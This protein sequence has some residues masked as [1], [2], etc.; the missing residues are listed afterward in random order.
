MPVPDSAGA[1]QSPSSRTKRH[2]YT[3]STYP[4]PPTTAVTRTSPA[5]HISD[6]GMEEC[7][8]IQVSETAPDRPAETMLMQ[9]ADGTILTSAA[10]LEPTHPAWTPQQPAR[11]LLWEQTGL[12]LKGPLNL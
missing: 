9:P 11:I 8:R 5:L 12:L 4:P 10:I 6:R 2:R 3:Y 1:G 7:E